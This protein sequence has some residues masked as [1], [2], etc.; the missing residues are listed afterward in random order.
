MSS[1]MIGDRRILGRGTLAFCVVLCADV[2]M[3]QAIKG[4]AT[5]RER[6]ALPAGSIFELTLEDVSRADAPALVIATSRIA[7]PG[8][9]PIAFSMPY[10]PARIIPNQ[11]ANREAHDGGLPGIGWSCSAGRRRDWLCSKAGRRRRRQLSST[12]R[13]GNSSGSRAKM[14]R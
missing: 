5:Y 11:G 2:A 6:M 12:E 8:N 4:T 7:S 14:T 10:D 13:R 3:A 9:P 1:S